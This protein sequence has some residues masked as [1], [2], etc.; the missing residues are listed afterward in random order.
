MS[1]AELLP[2]PLGPRFAWTALLLAAF[3]VSL[4]FTMRTAHRAGNGWVVTTAI[5]S[6]ILATAVVAFGPVPGVGGILYFV[7]STIVGMRLAPR[8]AVIWVAASVAALAGCLFVRDHSYWLISTLSYGVG[9]FAVF[10]IA[11]SYRGSLQARAESQELL[12]ELTSAQGRLRDLA[13]MEERQRLAREM[14]DAVGHRLTAAAMLLEGAA[15]LIPS[16]PERATRMVET[17]RQQV[18]QGLDELRTAVSALRAPQA[19]AQSMREVLGAI[20]DVFSRGTD[21][22][23]ALQI[24]S[25][26]PEPDPDRKLVIVRTCQEALT[27]VQKHAAASRVDLALHV[28]AAAYVLTCRDD[29][30]GP[31]SRPSTDRE[32]GSGLRNLQER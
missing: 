19:G 14:H 3:T 7:I 23:V 4:H 18:R 29:G 31:G 2:V 15:R 10:A 12:R 9:Y 5:V 32:Q 30:R 17:S 22:S 24:A 13:V 27:N 6:W 26:V 8:H 16:E 21:A 20:V 28:E 25:D 11:L 1:V